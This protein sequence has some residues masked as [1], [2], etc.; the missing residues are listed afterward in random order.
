[1]KTEALICFSKEELGTYT[2]LI[3]GNRADMLPPLMPLLAYKKL[4][5]PWQYEP[6]V[7]LRKQKT[8]QAVRIFAEREYTAVLEVFDVKTRNGETFLKEKLTLA[9]AAGNLCYTGISHL[10]TGGVS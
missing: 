8:D 9:D 7:I 1:M 3:G 2:E 6:P 5:I 10:V 4:D